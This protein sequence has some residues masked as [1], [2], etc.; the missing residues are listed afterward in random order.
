MRVLYA[1][2]ATQDRTGE[3]VTSR[4]RE[5]SRQMCSWLRPLPR[6]LYVAVFDRCS[7]DGWGLQHTREKW[8]ETALC[9]TYMVLELGTTRVPCLISTASKRSPHTLPLLCVHVVY[10]VQNRSRCAYARASYRRGVNVFAVLGCYAAWLVFIFRRYGTNRWSHPRESSSQDLKAELL[11]GF[12]VTIV[13]D[14]MWNT[15][16]CYVSCSQ[17]PLPVLYTSGNFRCAGLILL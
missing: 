12:F 1:R 10:T 7:W 3:C 14:R 9:C 16:I 4:N 8:E 15:C 2:A 11:C 13:I 5:I 17:N 6:S